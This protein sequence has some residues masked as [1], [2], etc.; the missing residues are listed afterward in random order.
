MQEVL[1]LIND[2]AGVGAGVLGLVRAPDRRLPQRGHQ[3]RPDQPR[4]VLAEFA[5]GKPGEQDPAVEHVGRIERAGGGAEEVSDEPAGGDRAQLGQHRPRLL[6]RSRGGELVVGAP[7]RP[8]P[9]GVA[10]LDAAGGLVAEAGVGEQQWNVGQ[11]GA[12]PPGEG[13]GRGTQRVFDPRP[14][15]R[16][17]DAVQC[18]H[19]VF[20]DGFAAESGRV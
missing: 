2:D 15:P 17:K 8:D 3:Q 1:C 7:E 5:L 19:E 14:P 6:R 13:V 11:G 20:G 10:A 16:L 18:G 12:W 9:G 4:G